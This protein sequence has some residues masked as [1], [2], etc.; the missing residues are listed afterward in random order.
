MKYEYLDWIAA[1]MYVRKNERFDSVSVRAGIQVCI[2]AV[3]VD[4]VSPLLRRPINIDNEECSKGRTI[5]VAYLCA[6]PLCQL[7]LAS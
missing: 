1:Y 6:H 7:W 3:V 5:W 2:W 4:R